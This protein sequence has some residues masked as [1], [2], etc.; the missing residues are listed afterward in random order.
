MTLDSNTAHRYGGG[1]YMIQRALF[2]LSGGKIS[3]NTAFGGG[4]VYTGGV[5]EMTGGKISNNKAVDG[6]GGDDVDGG[7]VYVGE[8]GSFTMSGDAVI[9]S[10]TAHRYGGGVCVTY[11]ALF[12]LSGGKISGNTAAS[13]GGV[14][15]WFGSFNMSD[16]TIT[17]NKATNY[18]GGVYNWY[19]Y[20][21]INK[22]GGEIS[23]NTA[24]IGNDTYLAK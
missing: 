10:N 6:S 23:G 21:T 14:G 8:A 13:G 15:V 20:G 9:D 1:V 22:S 18:G 11:R 4:G 2:S 19:G 5:F 3:G 17:N 16:G 7:G 12:S 24:D